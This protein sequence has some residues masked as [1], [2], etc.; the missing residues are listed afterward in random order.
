MLYYH[1]DTYELKDIPQSLVNDW[2]INNNPKLNNWILAP[3]KPDGEYAWNSGNW[4]LVTQ[5]VPQSI[6]ARQIRIWLIQN[7][8]SLSQIDSIIDNIS[9]TTLKNIT[10]V[11]WE[12]APYIERNH[13]MLLPLASGLG[14]SESDIDSAFI[15]AAKL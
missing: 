13:P 14:L 2:E 7:N 4:E 10:K 9:D 8:I 3:I 15:Q 6:S 1:K 5:P 12:Y 11:E